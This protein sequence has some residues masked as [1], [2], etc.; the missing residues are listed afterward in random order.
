M[1]RTVDAT[2]ASAHGLAG[3]SVAELSGTG[4]RERAEGMK[5]RVLVAEDHP[6]VREGVIRALERDPGMA[7][8]G[9]ADNGITALELA[10]QLKPDVMVLDL[11]MPGLGG[12]VVLERLRAE[13]PLSRDHQ[14]TAKKCPK[15]LKEANAAR[16]APY[17][18]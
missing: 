15:T 12:A 10:R 9:E 7:I 5:I 2:P 1:N 11:R 17:L 4:R 3:T 8:V 6:L 18:S 13:L 16:A 14:N